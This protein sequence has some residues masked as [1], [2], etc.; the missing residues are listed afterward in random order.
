MITPRVSIVLTDPPRLR[1]GAH[2]GQNDPIGYV[3][4]EHMRL[5]IQS[6]TPEHLLAF[7][8]AFQEAARQ[9]RLQ[10]IQAVA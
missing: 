1:T 3:E 6:C 2:G 8:D 5:C 4:D 9:L 7:A 10:Q